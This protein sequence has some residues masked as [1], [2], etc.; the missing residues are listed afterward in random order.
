MNKFFKLGT[1]LALSIF[2]NL[3]PTTI[4]NTYAYAEQVNKT[5]DTHKIVKK[6]KPKVAPKPREIIVDDS[7]ETEKNQTTTIQNSKE[8]KEEKTNQT[9]NND[10]ISKKERL[11]K[12]VTSNNQPKP[13]QDNNQNSNKNNNENHDEVLMPAQT[14]YANIDNINVTINTI[15]GIFPSDA[16]MLIQNVNKIDAMNAAQKLLSD[17]VI[18]AIAIDI[19]FF[20][21]NGK[22]IEPINP[23]GVHIHI[24]TS[25]V[26]Q[27]TNHSILHIDNNGISTIIGEATNTSAD[28]TYI[29]TTTYAIIGSETYPEENT[30]HRTYIF[31]Y[32]DPNH[33]DI[34]KEWK[35]QT[36]KNGENLYTPGVPTP[37]SI[38]S[39][40]EGW[41][42]GK[43][44]SSLEKQLIFD[45]NGTIKINDI[46]GTEDQ[47]VYYHAHYTDRNAVVFWNKDIKDI[48]DIKYINFADSDTQKISLLDTTPTVEDNEVHIGWQD[49]TTG[50]YYI[51]NNNV[52]NLS[53]IIG[54][55]YKVV[56]NIEVL[57]TTL[58]K[59]NKNTIDLKAVII[60]KEKITKEKP[61]PKNPIDP[62]NNIY[63]PSHQ[64]N[65]I[66]YKTNYSNDIVIPEYN[67]KNNNQ[68]EPKN[69]Q[70]NTQDSTK[71][72][73]KSKITNKTNYQKKSIK[74][75]FDISTINIKWYK[76][77][78]IDNNLH[79]D[80]ITINKMVYHELDILQNTIEKNVVKAIKLNNDSKTANIKISENKKLGLKLFNSGNF[81]N[82]HYYIRGP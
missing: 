57:K 15:E 14:F 46:T 54:S 37:S 7:V 40:F 75:D 5:S 41:Y 11:P 69:I 8:N 55:N 22:R 9:N 62:P 12:D 79:I 51:T 39:Y 33:H 28:F 50:K 47:V 1:A 72:E 60:P 70:T 48:I 21:K 27:G 58:N 52:N 19:D 18:D 73:N 20:D 43:N 4:T 68:I 61:I 34:Y 24:Q 6:Q 76:T 3:A 64:N 16:R 2:V 29:G 30:P 17:K 82:I 63:P 53:S 35:K 49:I 77:T 32:E 81:K 71:E 25:D 26:I 36:I 38:T 42:E 80:I 74:K 23:N 44:H 66:K 10:S 56:N 78:T 65:T 31:Y 59:Q 45:K 67:Q 13:T